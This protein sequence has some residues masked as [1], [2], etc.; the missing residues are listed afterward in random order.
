M[1]G[2]ACKAA[3][4]A[5]PSCPVPAVLVLFFVLPFALLLTD[6]VRHSTCVC[7]LCVCACV[8]VYIYGYLC[9]CVCVCVCTVI[10]IYMYIYMYM[11]I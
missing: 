2:P 5:D 6:V 9:V 4:S 10:G 3:C 11:N 7:G 8:Y 1:P